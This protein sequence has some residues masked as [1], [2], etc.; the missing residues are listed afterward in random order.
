VRSRLNFA[1]ALAL[2]MALAAQPVHAQQNHPPNHPP[3][4]PHPYAHPHAQRRQAQA[5][6]QNAPHPNAAEPHAD[7]ANAHPGGEGATNTTP[8]TNAATGGAAQP[9]PNV[10]SRL[11]NPPVTAGAEQGAEHSFGNLPQGAQQRLRDMSPQ[12]QE[13]FLQ[14]NQRFQNLPPQQQQQIRQRLQQWNKLTP[15]ER[16]AIRDREQRMER[17]SPEQRQHL[18]ND[19]YPK[20]KQMTP[21]RRQLLMGRMHTLQGMSPQDR[22]AAL[23]DPKFMQGLNPD[24]Q[25]MLRDLN[26]LGGGPKP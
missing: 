8:H 24:E 16:N 7:G 26:S 21:E 13:R 15:T 14:N 2:F 18:M 17:L 19:V 5:H 22:Q 11:G 3:N 23:N 12:E 1:C 10:Q 6:P 25:S 9:P 20:W 4:H